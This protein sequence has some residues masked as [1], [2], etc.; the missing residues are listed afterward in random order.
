MSN[1]TR[2]VHQGATAIMVSMFALLGLTQGAL[3]ATDEQMS[4]HPPNSSNQNQPNTPTETSKPV[5]ARPQPATMRAG[6]ERNEPTPTGMNEINLD[7]M[8]FASGA[9]AF[10]ATNDPGFAT[11][12]FYNGTGGGDDCQGQ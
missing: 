5:E 9:S 12:D 11:G 2:R 1:K 3:A 8:L 7:L 6:D 10:D 4:G